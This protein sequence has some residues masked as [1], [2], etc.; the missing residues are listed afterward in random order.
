MTNSLFSEPFSL[1]APYLAVMRPM[2]SVS[3]MDFPCPSPLYPIKKDKLIEKVNLKEAEEIEESKE[4][5]GEEGMRQNEKV[6]IRLAAFLGAFTG[7]GVWG[8]T[9]F[10]VIHLE[11]RFFIPSTFS[12]QKKGF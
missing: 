4:T 6:S 1:E 11:R 5:K 9:S 8:F 10:T 2:I 7:I 12:S 3:G